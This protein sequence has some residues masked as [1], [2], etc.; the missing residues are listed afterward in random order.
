[1]LGLPRIDERRGAALA[2]EPRPRGI[3]G[4]PRGALGVGDPRIARD[5]HRARRMA[6]DHQP[7]RD[8]RSERVAHDRVAPPDPRGDRGDVVGPVALD[9]PTAQVTG[10]RDPLAIDRHV[11]PARRIAREAMQ[12]DAA[13]GDTLPPRRVLL[14][15]VHLRGAMT[16]GD[17][18]GRF[19]RARAATASTRS[20]TPGSRWSRTGS[21]GL[22]RTRA[23]D[24]RD[25]ARSKSAAAANCDG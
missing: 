21:S 17:I 7:E 19:E 25:R 6:A 22:T 14:L 3:A 24:S 20:T 12:Q 15:T 18:A 13:H 1:W 4:S 9:R 10:Q 11:V 2:R 16:A 8:T 23:N 5:Q